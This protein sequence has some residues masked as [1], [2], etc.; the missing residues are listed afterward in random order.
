MRRGLFRGRFFE[1]GEL[2]RV[3]RLVIS[4]QGEE[5]LYSI[6]S[7]LLR[8]ETFI[9]NE[10]GRLDQILQV[11]PV[12]I[13]KA[14]QLVGSTPVF[15]VGRPDSPSQEVSQ[16]NK[17]AVILVLDVDGPPTIFPSSNSLAIDDDVALRS[18]DSERNHRL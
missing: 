13:R 1:G 16:V 12:I 5:E 6:I 17:L 10:S 3:G 11:S 7:H 15:T 9:V 14:G 18:D 4:G 2:C 8:S